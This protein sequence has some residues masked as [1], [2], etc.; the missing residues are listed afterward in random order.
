VVLALCGSGSCGRIGYS[1]IVGATDMARELPD[2]ASPVSDGSAV[3]PDTA[4]R[5]GADAFTGAAGPD[6]APG[7][8]VTSRDVGASDAASSAVDLPMPPQTVDARLDATPAPDAAAPDAGA[9]P[10]MILPSIDGPGPSDPIAA[11]ADVTANAD[12]SDS[13]QTADSPAASP[14]A[15]P[16]PDTPPPA[17]DLAADVGLDLG[18]EAGGFDARADAVADAPADSAA[19]T[20]TNG[21]V[22]ICDGRDNNC[23]GGVDEGA[24]CATDCRGAAFQGRGYM[25]CTQATTWQLA[26][27][28]CS[29]AGMTLARVDNGAEDAFIES[30]RVELGVARLWLGGSDRAREGDWV[31]TD[32][33]LFWRGGASG[34]PIGGLYTN[35]VMDEPGNSGVFGEDCLIIRAFGWADHECFGSEAFVCKAQ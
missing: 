32:G 16:G 35:F 17:L 12:S 29:T 4:Q 9:I 11:P 33:T 26:A 1:P 2:S 21:G 13:A 3:V 22:E 6:A 23:S 8:D 10:D 27:N 28:R 31:W 15:P 5:P 18:A 14:D 30:K 34:M 25:F 19:C 20:P 7:A 24:L